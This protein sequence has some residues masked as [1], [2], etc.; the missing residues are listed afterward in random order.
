MSAD[1]ICIWAFRIRRW[2]LISLLSSRTGLFYFT[3]FSRVFDRMLEGINT[4]T[5]EFQSDAPS[6]DMWMKHRLFNWYY[7]TICNGLVFDIHETK[8]DFSRKEIPVNG[9]KKGRLEGLQGARSGFIFVY[10]S[11]TFHSIDDT[12]LCK[13]EAEEDGYK[14]I[15]GEKASIAFTI[16]LLKAQGI[17][18]YACDSLPGYVKKDIQ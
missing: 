7:C 2:F 13:S 15:S 6:S 5:I 18:K 17:P 1:D 4:C 10:W 3:I 8:S 12:Y 9:E 16:H 11:F 14:G